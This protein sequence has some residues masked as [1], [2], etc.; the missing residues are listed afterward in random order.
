MYEVMTYQHMLTTSGATLFIDRIGL[1]PYGARLVR[2]AAPTHVACIVPAMIAAALFV[3]LAITYSLIVPFRKG[4]V[5]FR[6]SVDAQLAPDPIAPT[7]MVL[8]TRSLIVLI[9]EL[10]ETTRKE[11]IW[12]CFVYTAV[13]LIPVISACS[14][15]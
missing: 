13:M 2:S 14:A 3:A 1:I 15:T 6:Y 9:P 10:V 12:A 7:V 8:P 4:Y 11:S 5:A